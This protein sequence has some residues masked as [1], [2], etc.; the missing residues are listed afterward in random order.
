MHDCDLLFD[1]MISRG[2][3]VVSLDDSKKFER[4]RNL[5]HE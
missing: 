5:D 2:I 4:K 3:C 1:D